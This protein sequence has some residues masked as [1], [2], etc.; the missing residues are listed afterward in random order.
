MSSRRDFLKSH[1]R[2][3]EPLAVGGVVPEFIANTA[4]AAEKNAKKKDTILVVVELTGGNDGLNT[5]APFGDDLYHKARPTLAFNKKDIHKLDD[6]HALHPRMNEMKQ[7]YDQKRLAVVQ[8][9]GYP[10]RTA[11]TS[12]AWTSGNSPIRNARKKAAGWRRS[13][14]G[15]TIADAGVPECTSAKN[16]C[17]SR[18]KAS[19]AASSASPI[20]PASAFNS[21]ATRA[22]ARNCSEDLNA[23]NDK[24]NADLA[25][26]VR[27]RQ[28]Q[29]YT[30]LRKLEDALNEAGTTNP[31]P[32]PVGGS[33][34][35]FR[36]DQ[37]DLKTLNGKL[38][39]IGRLIQKNLGTRIYHVQHGGFDTHANQAEEHATLLGELSSSIGA[40]IN[41]LTGEESEPA[42]S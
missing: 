22:T 24:T 34:A 8:G 20:A 25:A 6:Y 10:N 28:L 37:G 21:T 17:P 2:R 36:N 18:C 3:V 41:T 13:I 31:S 32:T 26:F 1:T 33:R 15:M 39:L 30:S 42:W 27:K 12:R 29:T 35:A 11:R 38:G 16:A 5:V 40:L 9:V 23:E 4:R 14:P 7:L 19:T